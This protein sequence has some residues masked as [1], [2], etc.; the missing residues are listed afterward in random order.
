MIIKGFFK[1]LSMGIAL[2]TLLLNVTGTASAHS[3][4]THKHTWV[5]HQ[6]F[7][8]KPNTTATYTNGLNPSQ[9]KI[10]YGINQLNL[11]G[12]GETIAIID[13]YGSPTINNDLQSFD[14]RFNL[15]QA[16]F[17]VVYPTGKP[18][19]TNASWALETSMDVEWAHALA[20]DA[21]IMLVVASSSSLSDLLSAV[22]YATTHGAQIVSNSW[23]GTEFSGEDNY[24]SHFNHSGITYV[25][26]SGDNGE[27]DLWPASSPYVVSAGGTTL[28][29]DSLGDYQSESAW[30]G[31]G[32]GLS[33]YESRPTYQNAERKIVKNSRGNPDISFDADP[34]TGVAVYDSTLYQSQQGWF[35]VGGTSLSAPSWAALF[36]LADQ[37]RTSTLSSSEILS[38]LYTFGSSSNYNN[39][40]HD[41]V[42][43]SSGYN[44]SNGYDLVTGLGSP[45][46]NQLIPALTA[47]TNNSPK[48]HGKH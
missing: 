39:Y 44:A 11:T 25:A 36:S 38:A 43:G 3:Q 10:A 17:N 42:T 1:K 31:S 24:D 7:K 9:V 27:G 26:S 28:N 48:K 46:A 37:N 41:I 29:V 34:N 33:L 14:T 21:K 30:S 19:N 45:I 22:D 5:S 4:K 12:T 18:Q 6:P 2:S 23:G 15:P 47:S 40:F 35:V 16:N 32:G 20:P 8:V 13:A